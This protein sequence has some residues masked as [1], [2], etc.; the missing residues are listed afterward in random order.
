[1]D[2]YKLMV[3]VIIFD[4]NVPQHAISY[5]NKPMVPVLD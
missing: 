3:P 4:T 2:M 1:M 5:G